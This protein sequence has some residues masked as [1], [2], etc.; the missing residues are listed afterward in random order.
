MGLN[1][2]FLG[3]REGTAWLFGKCGSRDIHAEL[4]TGQ[5]VP[6]SLPSSQYCQAPRA[7][8]GGRAFTAPGD[9]EG[10]LKEGLLNES[11]AE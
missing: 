7:Q 9:L 6:R 11:E 5:R 8:G 3:E 2:C 4:P 1:H 10:R